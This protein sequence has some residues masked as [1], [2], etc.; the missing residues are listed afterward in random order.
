M[1]VPGRRTDK[2][3]QP[4]HG[5][6]WSVWTR[7]VKWWLDPVERAVRHLRHQLVANATVDEAYLQA[8]AMGCSRGFSACGQL[9]LTAA[10]DSS[11][12]SGGLKGGCW[13]GEVA[14]RTGDPES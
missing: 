8:G 9:G 14:W 13:T 4:F 6:V 10:L 11:R 12:Y 3:S 1:A 2:G 5:M 7:I